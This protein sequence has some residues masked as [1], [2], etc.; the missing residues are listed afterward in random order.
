MVAIQDER[1]REMIQLTQGG[2]CGNL[3][4][5]N[6]GG[7]EY[8]R[9]GND[10]VCAYCDT[11]YK[12]TNDAPIKPQVT[13][14]LSDDVS[15]LLEKCKEEPDRARRYANIILEID[16]FNKKAKSILNIKD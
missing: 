9:Q 1:K 7:S 10:I 11:K 2:L 14:D 16:P 8:K 13:V 3:N 6:C 5:K 4:V 15:R 12:I